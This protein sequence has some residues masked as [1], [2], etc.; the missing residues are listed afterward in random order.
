LNRW[1]NIH[2]VCDVRQIL[3]TE[4]SAFK[5]KT[6]AVEMLGRLNPSCIDETRAKFIHSVGKTAS[7]EII[8]LLTVF[9]MKGSG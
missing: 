6:I 8:N 9:A 1:K 7:P 2:G 3:V 5:F 4:S